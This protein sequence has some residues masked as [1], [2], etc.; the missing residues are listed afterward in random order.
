M[1]LIWADDFK[2]FGDDEGAMSDGVYG[3]AV[4]MTLAADPDPLASGNVVRHSTL[5]NGMRFVYPSSVTTAGYAGR[6]WF[7]TLPTSVLPSIIQFRNASNAAQV[8]IEVTTTGAI[9]ARRGFATTGTVLGTSEPVITANA[10]NHVEVKVL[11]SD[12]V[13]TVHVQVNGLEVL[14][15]T[16]QDTLDSGS[17]EISQIFHASTR[18]D[19]A[20]TAS[21]ANDA[22]GLTIYRKDAVYWNDSGTVNNDFF[23]PVSVIRLAVLA[24]DTFTWAASTGTT[25]YNLID[26]TGPDDADYVEADS[27]PPAASVFTL[28]DLPTDVTSVR[29]LVSLVRAKN[30]DGGDGKL[31]VSLVSNGSDALGTDRQLTTAET[32]Y[33]D[34]SEL[35]PD[36]G[37]AWTPAEVDAAKIKI[38]RT[39]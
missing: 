2:S 5:G 22:T 20:I 11:V 16:G 21:G 12:T 32:Y 34:V 28:E 7:A 36:T 18:I 27:T 8:T 35:S 33:R 14:A 9:Q 29:G 39:L 13:G 25:G 23:G 17:A 38:D 24:D 1:A 30:T 3:E 15:L 6:F 19:S 31:Q 4:S 37:V 26:E 10:W